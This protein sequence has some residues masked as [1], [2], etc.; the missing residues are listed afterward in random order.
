M[1][2]INMVGAYKDRLFRKQ[3]YKSIEYQVVFIE[4]IPSKKLM[5]T[6][7]PSQKKKKFLHFYVDVRVIPKLLTL[8]LMQF[9]PY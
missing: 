7:R 6:S 3:W 8:I 9:P 2:P 5:Q 4:E 1:A